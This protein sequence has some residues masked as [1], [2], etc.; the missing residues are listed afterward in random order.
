MGWKGAVESEREFREKWGDAERVLL[1]VRG[2]DAG[3]AGHIRFLPSGSKGTIAWCKW[4][5][6]RR[7]FEY[8]ERREYVD[9]V[10]ILGAVERVGESHRLLGKDLGAIAYYVAG[11]TGQEP[12]QEDVINGIV[13]LVNRHGVDAVRELDADEIAQWLVEIEGE[14]GNG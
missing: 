5:A 14:F 13:W 9:E 1:S 3:L 11:E 7:A 10:E 2:S 4:N 12:G 8:G 6:G